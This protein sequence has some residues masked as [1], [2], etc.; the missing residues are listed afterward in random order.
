MQD[1]QC[2][3]P[4]AFL[5]IL[6][7][8]RS[9]KEKKKVSLHQLKKPNKKLQARP[10]QHSYK[11]RLD[12][13]GTENPFT[14]ILQTLLKHFPIQIWTGSFHQN[15][16]LFWRR[17]IV[18]SYLGSNNWYSHLVWCSCNT[19]VPTTPWAS[20]ACQPRP[21]SSSIYRVSGGYRIP[22]PMQVSITL[23]RWQKVCPH[24][25]LT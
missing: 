3:I 5:F 7:W 23:Q 24:L 20:P 11:P 6:V 2:Q 19:P 8:N 10:S 14:Q 25:C 21:T 1:P 13:K 4:T 22:T 17:K 16:A 9:K 15:L 12:K 18:R